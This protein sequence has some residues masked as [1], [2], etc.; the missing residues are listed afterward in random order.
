[1]SDK[2]QKRTLHSLFDHLI[3]AGQQRGRHCQSE[4]FRGLHIDGQ[5]IFGRH[6]NRQV[7][8]LLALEDAVDKAGRLTVL[9][10]E[11]RPI[12]D[13]APGGDEV[14]LVVDRGQIIRSR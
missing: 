11:I 5:L 2:C 9:L 3:G 8:R 14:M 6:L 1:M 13:R 10:N 12:G 7:G 4:R